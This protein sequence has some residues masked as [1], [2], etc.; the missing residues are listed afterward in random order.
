MKSLADAACTG[1][2]WLVIS[3]DAVDRWPSLPQVIQSAANSANHLSTGESE[4]QLA[5]ED[6]GQVERT[7]RRWEAHDHM[8][9]DLKK[10]SAVKTFAVD[11]LSCHL[12]HLF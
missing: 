2:S 10:R 4:L 9:P 8:V 11:D 3:R 5:Q 6:F 1:M 7:V 12:S